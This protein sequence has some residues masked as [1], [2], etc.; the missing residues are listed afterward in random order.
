ATQRSPIDS[1]GVAGDWN[2][3]L[4]S[5]IRISGEAFH[6][7][8]LGI[9]S[10][11]IAQSSVVI[12][13]RARGINST[14]GWIELHVEAPASYDGPW[15]KFS[16]NGGYGIEDNRDQDLLAGLRKRNQTVM[17]NGQFKLA[18]NFIMALEYRHIMT[19]FFARPATDRTLSWVNL[20]FLYSF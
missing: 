19:D 8:A 4:G 1:Y 13:G 2:A 12:D 18:A 11:D 14:G 7:R 20:A 6:G 16:A 10:G 17:A 5:G 3:W 15:K 9:L